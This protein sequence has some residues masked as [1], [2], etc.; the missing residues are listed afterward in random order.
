MDFFDFAVDGGLRTRCSYP[1]FLLHLYPNRNFIFIMKQ[2]T[3]TVADNKERLF[4]ELMKS[5]SFVKKIKALA[6]SNDIP[7]EHKTIVR[8]RIASTKPE[9]QLNWDDVKDNFRLE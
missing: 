7:E 3:I 2:F 4:M 5:L 6:V 1:I 8:K 9:E